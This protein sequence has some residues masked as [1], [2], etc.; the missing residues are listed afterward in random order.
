MPIKILSEQVAAR[1]AA[2]E[3]IER[4][5]SVVKE[6]VENA[7][8]AG[9]TEIKVESREGGRR[10][11]RVIDNGCGI[12]ADEVELAFQRHA[13]SKLSS[14]EDLEH[15]TTLGFRGEALPSIAAVAH[16][17]MVTR[18]RDEAAGSL[19]RLEGG[20]VVRRERR[21]MAPGTVV[22]V[23]HLFYNTPARLKF[24]K[25][26]ATEAGHIYA[27]VTRYA[28]AYPEL[29]FSLVNDGRLIFQSMG[30]GQVRDVLAQV[31]GLETA[32]ALLAVE[33]GEAEGP[34]GRWSVGL[35]GLVSPPSVHR[36][37][38][39][40]ISL[41]VNRRWIH[42]RSLNYAVTEAYRTLL[43]VGRFPLV[44][45]FLTMDPAAV[46]VNVHPAKAE[47]RFREAD[48]VFAA[49]QRAVRRTLLDQAPMP[50]V[51]QRVRA[52]GPV[53]P[54]HEWGERH[55]PPPGQAAL[56]IQRTADVEPGREGEGVP[57]GRLPM[58]RV[59]G[60][61]AQAYIVAEGPEGLYLIDQHAAHER[62]LY[63]QL[64]AAR[65]SQ[66][67]ISQQLLEP[68]TVELSPEQAGVLAEDLPLLT[69]LGFVLEHFG[70]NTYL[71]RAVP[72]ILQGKDPAGALVAVV[73]EMLAGNV[74]L[75]AERE[76]RLI[77]SVCK[78]GAIKA[79]Q[80]LS[81]AE[82]QALVQQLEATSA[83][84]TC[85][86]GRPTMIHLSAEFLAREFG[87]T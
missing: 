66:K 87:R 49:V 54:R 80:T 86:H 25:T 9:A 84:R 17:T 38:R 37:S 39:R 78:Q 19:I 15:I 70:G 81:M 34:G 10:L 3:V 30:T 22:T 11:I 83:P 51:G 57:G 45:L 55:R 18:S 52:G 7:I 36:G 76:A 6:L 79:G 41:F 14:V 71:L 85:P 44:V 68:Q 65:A 56:E 24:L 75:G 53:W 29:R 20:E 59:V 2:G 42:D 33:G 61:V 60:Q 27:L 16:V 28:M 13:T 12:P 1:I 69:E 72:A 63:E 73:D 67:N 46:D 5:A 74:P 40:D 32:S 77:A 64:Q 4:P 50:V 58:L 8:D 26:V 21:G 31:Y 47:V 82:M 48:A 62:V 43:P 23:E 35:E